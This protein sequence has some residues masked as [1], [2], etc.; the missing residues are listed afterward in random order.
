MTDTISS[1]V[2]KRDNSP[3]ALISQYRDDFAL[4][5]PPQVKVDTFVRVAQGALRRD[6]NLASA[7]AKDPGS[8]MS[9]LL[10]AARLGLEPGS[11][12]YWLTPRGG[13]VLG[14]VGYRGELELVYRAGAVSSVIAEIVHEGDRFQWRPG[15]DDRPQHEVDWFGDRGKAIGAYAY[16]VMKDGAVS[17]VAVVGPAEAK[18]AMEASGTAGS[19]HS[20]W[21]TDLGA[22]LLK[23]AIHRLAKFLPTSAEYRREQLRAVAEV[24]H[25]AD[26]RQVPVT[27]AH[28][29]L[30][31]VD[32]DGVILEAEVVEESA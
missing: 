17:K 6:R 23:T 19:S 22:M 32:D 18:R 8:L 30:P 15:M 4:V 7:A 13:K 5:L 14:I 10:E 20:P 9:A 16:A 21:K 29:D 24:A 25:V 3:A 31:A 1:A 27:V 11:D 26:A 12:E 2:A 28:H